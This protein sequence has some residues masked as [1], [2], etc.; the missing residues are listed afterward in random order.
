MRFR[1]HSQHFKKSPVCGI[2]E[3]AERGNDAPMKCPFD[4]SGHELSTQQKD[5]YHNN[6]LYIFQNLSAF[7]AV[8]HKKIC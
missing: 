3:S 6:I 2:L 1:I 5:C 8:E 7:S 4:F